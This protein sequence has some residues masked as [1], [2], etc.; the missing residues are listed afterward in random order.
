MYCIPNQQ[1]PM[2]QITCFFH[3]FAVSLIFIFLCRCMYVLSVSCSPP[4]FV[5]FAMECMLRNFLLHQEELIAVP[6]WSTLR[7]YF[8]F[9]VD[10]VLF[11][12]DLCI[13][14][15]WAS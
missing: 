6:L 13:S 15:F 5:C 2:L 8:R 3:Q 1:L 12:N 7:L 9:F 11:T 4:T 10:F 14:L